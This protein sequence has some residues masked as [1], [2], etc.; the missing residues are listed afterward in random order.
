MF[1]MNF[2]KLK[3]CDLYYQEAGSGILLYWY[4]EWVVTILH[5]EVWLPHS[6]KITG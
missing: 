6:R 2:L 3:N 4:T 1:S 5:G